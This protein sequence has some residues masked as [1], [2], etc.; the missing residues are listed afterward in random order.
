MTDL[1][2]RLEGLRA[3]LAARIS[4]PALS[5]TSRARTT[6]HTSARNRSIGAALVIAVLVA[7]VTTGS[8]IA[9]SNNRANTRPASPAAASSS[10]ATSANA[11]INALT[12]TPTKT[13]PSTAAPATVR[14][15]TSVQ[16]ADATHGFAL[17]QTCDSQ[18]SVCSSTL[19][20][21][22][23]GQ[24]W[25][26]RPLPARYPAATDDPAV[27]LGLT[28]LGPSS[29]Y[30]QAVGQDRKD[31]YGFHSADGGATWTAVPNGVNGTAE[32]IP[33]GGDLIAGCPTGGTDPCLTVV[34][35]V[36]R[37]ADGRLVRLAHQP[38]IVVAKANSA[39]L[40]DGAWWVSGTDLGKPA[41]AVS[42]DRGRTWHTSRLPD[43]PGRALFLSQ[44]TAAGGRL[45]ALAIGELPE[46]KNGL[47]GIYRSDDNGRTWL[48]PW[49]ATGAQQP[50]SA[51]GVGI[52]S[53]R[54]LVICDEA[55]PQRGWL[56]TDGGKS[57]GQASCPASGWIDRGR[58]GYLTDNG[59]TSDFSADGITWTKLR[60]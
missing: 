20:V 46:V 3:D 10:A 51:L 1:D 8:L 32:S 30:L 56:S 6:A 49:V 43:M 18:G 24:H 41:V 13:S 33:D 54:Q 50:R 2:D 12:L 37:P 26:E 57:F 38:D 7:V 11:G 4:R 5:P 21:T 28:A 53:G 34:L 16:M 36:R 29:L 23:D 35:T 27:T 9:K 52:A 48:R 59:T 17:L 44:I 31:D 15:L 45:W 22:Q 19:R 42:R 40:P 58:A 39:P 60:P 55:Q 25:I 14:N 47:L